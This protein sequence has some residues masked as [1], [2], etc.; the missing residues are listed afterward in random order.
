MWPDS[1]FSLD[2]MI[3]QNGVMVVYRK[4]FCFI[5]VSE[6]NETEEQNMIVHLIIGDEHLMII[7]Q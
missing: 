5:S 3:D 6:K 2:F 1:L 4:Y 7:S